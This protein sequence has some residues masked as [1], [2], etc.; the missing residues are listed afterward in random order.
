MTLS[1][2]APVLAL[3]FAAS[4][5]AFGGC[6]TP[7]QEARRVGAARMLRGT[8]ALAQQ[9]DSLLIIEQKL[10]QVIDSMTNLVGADHQRIRALEQELQQLR[11][12]NGQVPLPPE[13]PYSSPGTDPP[14]ATNVPSGLTAPATPPVAAPPTPPV[15]APATAPPTFSDRYHSALALF[16]EYKYSAAFAAF[17]SLARDDPHGKLAS[18]YEYW[19]GECYY[20]EHHYNMALQAFG[21]MLEQYA[22]SKKAAAAQFKIGECYERLHVPRIARA[23]YQRVLADYP[24]SEFRGRA[25]ARLKVLR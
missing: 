15:A 11:G 17:E 23:A 12:T 10:T 7:R 2:R 20:G 19:E 5:V 16:R 25:E 18:N 14:P 9:V 24:N 4:L 8:P 1:R 13:Y 21:Q 22:H 3:I 6:R